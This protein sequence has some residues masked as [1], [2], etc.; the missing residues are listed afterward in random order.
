M[1]AAR[2]LPSS[3]FGLL[4]KYQE[5]DGRLLFWYQHFSG[6]VTWRIKEIETLTSGTVNVNDER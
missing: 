6:K 2:L 3:D 1:L 5:R 4:Q